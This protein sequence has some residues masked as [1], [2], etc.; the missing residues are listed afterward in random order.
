LSYAPEKCV[1]IYTIYTIYTISYHAIS[2][3]LLL[4]EERA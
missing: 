4:R 1:R 2:I 3:T